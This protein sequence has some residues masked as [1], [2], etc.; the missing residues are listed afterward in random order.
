M[1]SLSLGRM[2]HA[3]DEVACRRGVVEQ[4]RRELA[5]ATAL[6]LAKGEQ[7]ADAEIALATAQLAQV[8]ADN[9]E[10]KAVMG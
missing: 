1:T 6:Y 8:T 4:L 9:E 5:E 3:A 7:L 10:R 2:R